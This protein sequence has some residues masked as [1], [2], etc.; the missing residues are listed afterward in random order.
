MSQNEINFTWGEQPSTLT[1]EY[2][3]EHPLPVN[4]NMERSESPMVRCTL[5]SDG[6][7]IL[8]D[9][10]TERECNAWRK[11]SEDIGYDTVDKITPIGQYVLNQQPS[12][13]IPI[14]WP[15]PTSIRTNKRCIWQVPRSESNHLYARLK[16]CWELPMVIT[17]VGLWE[18]SDLNRRWR[19]FKTSE[20]EEFKYHIDAACARDNGDRSFASLVIWLN[21]DFEGGELEFDNDIVIKPV[22]G[23]AVLFWHDGHSKAKRHRGHPVVRG[24]KYLIR[25]DVFYRLVQTS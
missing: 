1:T 25:T 14:I 9:L 24:V 11:M 3:S 23:D 16:T 20:G 19:F 17:D 6:I 8:N 21:D 7:W 10:L 2:S 22:K 15:A 5:A 4:W 12:T 18:T 13:G